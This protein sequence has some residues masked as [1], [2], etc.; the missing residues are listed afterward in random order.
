MKRL[1]HDFVS[2]DLSVKRFCQAAC[3]PLPTRDVSLI[4]TTTAS[5]K[6]NAR[7]F[8]CSNVSPTGYGI[9]NTGYGIRDTEYGI[10][11]TEYGIQR[12]RAPRGGPQG[13]K[14]KA[15]EINENVDVENVLENCSKMVNS[16]AE[17]LGSREL[18]F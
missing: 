4:K 1:L 11:N 5:P 7:M 17:I 6:V 18:N 2:R 3:L 15:R 9:R 12:G 14:G 8:K 16:G 13:E 10:R